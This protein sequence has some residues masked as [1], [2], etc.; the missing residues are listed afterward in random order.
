[1]TLDYTELKQE[2]RAAHDSY[3]PWGSNIAWL[4]C[5]CDEMTFERDMVVPTKW[6]FQSSLFGNGSEDQPQTEILRQTDDD[7]LLRFGTLLER[8]DR[9]LRHAGKSY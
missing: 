8:Y 7:N 3:D 2:Y 5:V 1:M 4:F 6:E 9:S